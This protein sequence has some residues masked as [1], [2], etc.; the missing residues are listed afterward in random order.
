MTL[1][2]RAKPD[3]SEFFI[4][5]NIARNDNLADKLEK[6][7]LPVSIHTKCRKDYTRPSSIDAFQKRDDVLSQPIL[8]KMP[9]YNLL[10][11]VVTLYSGNIYA[12]TAKVAELMNS[13][14][15]SH[16]VHDEVQ[17]K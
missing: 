1:F 11:A 13:Q 5:S 3:T 7:L 8:G 15:Y 17:V 9:S 6:V 2:F 12:T 16:T 10:S 4:S 14:F